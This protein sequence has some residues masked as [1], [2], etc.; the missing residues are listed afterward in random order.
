MMPLD[1]LT[2]MSRQHLKPASSL[3]FPISVNGTSWQL[4][5]K[6][7]G[8][9]F[10]FS[11]LPHIKPVFRSIGASSKLNPKPAYLPSVLSPSLKLEP[12]G[13]LLDS[14]LLTMALLSSLHFNTA[15]SVTHIHT[16]SLSHTHIC[17]HRH[18]NTYLHI[19]QNMALAAKGSNDCTSLV[20]NLSSLY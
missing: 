13:P 4:L 14:C 9:P 5:S 15:A 20:L 7:R 2:W 19:N 17:T 6:L 16:L 11:F 3:A 10:F 12:V 8:H 1:F 18:I